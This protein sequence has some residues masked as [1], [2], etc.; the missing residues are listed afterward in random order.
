VVMP[1][2]AVRQGDSVAVHNDVALFPFRQ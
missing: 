2:S 1:A